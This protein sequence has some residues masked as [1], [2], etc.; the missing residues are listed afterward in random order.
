MPIKEVFAPHLGRTVKLGRKRPVAMG[1]HMKLRHYLRA[2]L[3]P[4]PDAVDYSPKAMASLSQMYLN[5]RLGDCVIAGGYHCVGTWTGNANG[6]PFMVSDA[7][8]VADYGSIGGYNPSDPSTDQG[9]DEPTAF[10]WWTSHGFAD[11]SNLVGWLAVDA[12]NQTEVKTALDLFENLVYAIELPEAWISPFPSGPGFTWDVAGEPV[13]EN[14][15][16]VIAPGYDASGAVIATWALLGHITWAA[17]AK[18]CV[19][20][21]GGGLYVIVSPDMI[22]KGQDKAPNGVS[23]NDLLSDFQQMGGV[24]TPQPPAPTPVPIPPSG[25][26]TLQGAQ[27]A[28]SA[29][30]ASGYALMTQGQAIATAN[31][32]LA[33]YWPTT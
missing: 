12:T 31:A 10:D 24:V 9:C 21:A 1:P 4:P 22:A 29:A 11:G 20:S 26:A 16:C 7:Q 8:L 2:S 28:V 25:P 14:G 5:D 23:W 15:H 6:S 13:P 19:P 30:L 17:M 3:P 32:A 33:A 18:Y 27:D